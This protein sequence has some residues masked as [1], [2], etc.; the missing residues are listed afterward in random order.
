[1][2]S[3]RVDADGD[4]VLKTAD[5]ELRQKRP[6]AYQETA[7]GLVEVEVGYRVKGRRV[8][9]QLARYDQA[10]RLV[11]DPVFF[12]STYLGGSGSDTGHSIAVDGSG[13][14]YVTGQTT[15]T[16]FPTTNPQQVSNGGGED[17][18]VTKINAAGSARVYSTYLGGSS[19]DQGKGIAVDGSGNVYV[20]GYTL[21][22]NFPTSNPLQPSSGGSSD[23]FVTKINSAGNT[24]LYSTYL[25]G[26]GNDQGKSIAVDGSGNPYVTGETTSTNFPTTNPLQASFGGGSHDV[27]VTKI[28]AAGSARVYSTYLGGSGA[29]T[30]QGMAVDGSG[31]AYVTGLTTSTDF[32]VTNPL[33]AGAGGGTYD[34]FVTKINAAG[35]ARVYSTYLGGN[36]I[37][38][39]N[40]I[41][42]DGSGNAY[43][44]GY[45][46]STNFPTTNPVQAGFGGG[47]YDAFM[48]KINAAGSAPVYSTYFG[49]TG[50]DAGKGIAV[51]GSGNAY[52]TG[53]TSSTNF[54][55]TNPLQASSG[56]SVDAFVTKINAT[57]SARLY[58]TY[59]GGSGSEEGDGI[60][61]DGSGNAYVTG[62][63]FSTNF[64]TTNPLQA[65]N[66]GSS[67]AFILS[68]SNDTSPTVVSINP[69]TGSGI[70]QAFT[71]TFSDPNGYT[72]L[73]VVNILVNK[74]LDGR[75]G[76]YMAY[77]QPTNTLYLVNDEGTAL[78]PGLPLNGS[79]NVANSYC[80][81][82]GAGSSAVGNGNTLTLTLQMSFNSTSFP[83]D[84]VVFMAARD[85]A[86]NNTGWLTKGVWRVPGGPAFT[87][88]SLSPS[89]GSGTTQA[90]T[91]VYRD[92]T[93]ATN[94]SNAQLLFNADLNG[95]NACYLG[96]V[97]ATNQLYLVN[98]ASPG[99]QP[100]I[101]PNSGT[102]S[103]QNSQCIVNGAGTT[104]SA[105]GTDLTLTINLT[106]K[107]SFSGA[108]LAY[109]AAQTSTGGNT[110]WQ[111]RGVW[112]VP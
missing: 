55:T 102:G 61:L 16:N 103:A 63:T 39:A 1:V 112:T 107:A 44:T 62:H 36:G 72:D 20:T 95:N 22:T 73:D 64:P 49:G 18:F 11:I 26:S 67:D 60:A 94:I 3:L 37:D 98:D 80:A 34:A 96:Y 109:A 43:V 30:G 46:S 47:P 41:A 2:E 86:A 92:P 87:V 48:V 10:R 42:L 79:G 45:T 24:L 31:N 91:V 6:L 110:D 17:A 28:N 90:F 4:L 53:Y 100:P 65:S 52:L 50:D 81:I 33:Q 77:S 32:P 78:L 71:F 54:P 83:G 104:S 9:F 68:I 19:T 7:A 84:K 56:G 5:G 69:Q 21:S 85:L 105:S 108:K 8:A 23:A 51:D 14:A 66:G 74:F 99:L 12:Y 76:C 88:N 35:S 70:A 15:S 29:D 82:A 111:A 27:F 106:F 93:A 101:T 40:G 25:G 58:S 57:G 38:S 59:V 89:S 75:F 13:N 97:R